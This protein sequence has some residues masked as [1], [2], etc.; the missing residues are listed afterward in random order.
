M[1]LPLAALISISHRLSG[2]FV[3]LLI[4]CVLW[5]LQQSLA[6]E[7]QFT[8]LAHYF[9]QQGVKVLIWLL[10]AALGFHLLAGCRHLIMDLG[11]G[12][13]LRGGKV[14]AILVTL[15]ALVL[16]GLLGFWLWA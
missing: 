9:N 13:S 1:R 12:E 16:F 11:I 15:F 10:L 2:V 3:F 4:P 5:V 8:A 7:K 14:G 6:S